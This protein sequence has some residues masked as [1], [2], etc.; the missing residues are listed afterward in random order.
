MEFTKIEIEWI[1]KAIDNSD[2]YMISIDNDCISVDEYIEDEDCW[3]SVYV[4][5]NYGQDFIVK[6]LNYIG[7]NAECV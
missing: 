2:R 5:D 3:D 4:F 7:C 1:K 6:L